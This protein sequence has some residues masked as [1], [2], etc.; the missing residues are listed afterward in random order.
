MLASGDHEAW[1]APSEPAALV[2]LPT[3]A[4]RPL[5]GCRA[6]SEAHLGEALGVPEG[7]PGKPGALSIPW[8]EGPS[9]LSFSHVDR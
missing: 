5:P 9:G 3:G 8:R 4:Q 6:R 2:S 7:T 1:C